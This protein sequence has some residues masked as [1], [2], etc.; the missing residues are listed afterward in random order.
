MMRKI[1]LQLIFLCFVSFIHAQDLLVKKNGDEINVKILEVN[2]SEVKFK[3]QSGD[4]H[5]LPSS[6]V[7]MIKYANGDKDIFQDSQPQQPVYREALPG[8]L[9][10]ISSDGKLA[11]SPATAFGLSILFPGAGQL[12][13]GDYVKGFL[14]S[15][16][17]LGAITGAVI[18]Y[19]RYDFSYWDHSYS[20]ESGSIGL[21]ILFVC[22][23]TADYIWSIMDA[24][25]GAHKANERSRLLTWEVGK[26]GS[27][28]LKPNVSYAGVQGVNSNQSLVYGAALQFNLK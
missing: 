2:S 14:M 11:K 1:T 20:K 16:V 23:F 24:S 27:L 26:R 5:T 13:N 15:G 10:Y 7:F 3:N 17:A 8:S 9:Y 6:E 28:S 4:V 12:Y 18:T 25:A 22:V 19:P 21:C